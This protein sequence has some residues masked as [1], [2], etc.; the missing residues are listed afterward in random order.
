MED[1]C[2]RIENILREV[3]GGPGAPLPP[4]AAL[5]SAL[6]Q[7]APMIR[8]LA[9]AMEKKKR[10]ATNPAFVRGAKLPAL[11]A[12]LGARLLLGVLETLP[13]GSKAQRRHLSRHARACRRF[14][15]AN[16]AYWHYHRLGHTHLDRL[17]FAPG[18]T[19]PAGLPLMW[20][21]CPV[22]SGHEWVLAAV[23]A[24]EALAVRLDAARDALEGGAPVPRLPWAAG[25][26]DIVELAYALHAGGVFGPRATL[27]E[28]LAVFESA[29]GVRVD[30]PSRVFLELR[31]RRGP[32]A[33]F[34]ALLGEALRRR[35]EEA[36][37]G[38]P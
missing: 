5:A 13:P 38:R 36:D 16:P 10:V 15:K 32:R 2:A 11:A 6:D 26:A 14:L 21:E 34:L 28:I 1:C 20:D 4:A 29:F 24:H 18:G 31:A 19:I 9:A 35:M 17:Y 3:V 27:R 8:R 23:A 33:R 12:V 30:Q 37:E 7:A 22:A 25:K